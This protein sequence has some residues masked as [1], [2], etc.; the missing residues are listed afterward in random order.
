MVTLY[1]PS[2]TQ[3]IFVWQERLERMAIK[4]RLVQQ[5]AD[6]TPLLQY[7]EDQIQGTDAIDKYLDTLEELVKS[8]YEDRCDKYEF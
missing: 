5:Q 4:H 1:Y 2:T 6:S 7:G 3:K 8:W